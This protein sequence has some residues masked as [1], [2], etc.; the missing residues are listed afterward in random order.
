MLDN[1]IYF[2][3]DNYEGTKKCEWPDN[4]QPCA[5]YHKVVIYLL[6]VKLCVVSVFFFACLFNT[7]INNG[8]LTMTGE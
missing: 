2:S 3:S 1:L 8:I 5:Q 4:V 6:L 7:K